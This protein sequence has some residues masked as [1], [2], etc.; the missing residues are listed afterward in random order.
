MED[1][2][3]Q[4]STSNIHGLGAMR[5]PRRMRILIFQ[6]EKKKKHLGT[7]DYCGKDKT[8]VANK[9]NNQEELTMSIRFLINSWQSSTVR[10]HFPVMTRT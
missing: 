10:N 7:K 9:E 2:K 6:S 4:F 5:A 8:F 3:G 1:P